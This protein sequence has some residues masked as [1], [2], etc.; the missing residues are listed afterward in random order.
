M[1]TKSVGMTVVV[2]MCVCLLAF[3]M[4]DLVPEV[5]AQSVLPG[6]KAAKIHSFL[7]QANP[8]AWTPV[9]EMTPGEHGFIITDLAIQASVSQPGVVALQ[10]GDGDGQWYA[11]FNWH[12]DSGQQRVISLRSGLRVPPGAT[13][14]FFSNGAGDQNLTIAGY[15]F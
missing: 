14:R 13:V 1:M 3:A 7:G 12:L 5:G 9:V 2:S 15:E 8:N 10:Y 4:S 6:G 11:L